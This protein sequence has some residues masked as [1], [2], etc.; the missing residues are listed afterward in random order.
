MRK[1]LW[2]RGK[3][4]EESQCSGSEKSILEA[5]K[6]FWKRGM[7]SGREEMFLEAIQFATEV[8]DTLCH[9]KFC[10]VYKTNG[11]CIVVLGNILVKPIVC[12]VVSFY[13]SS[14]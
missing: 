12:R 2:K 7:Y 8:V 10:M 3:I 13:L 14:R 1:V 11:D 6:V 5:S 4:L 9:H